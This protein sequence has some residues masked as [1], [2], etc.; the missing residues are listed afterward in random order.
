MERLERMFAQ[1]FNE[2]TQSQMRIEQLERTMSEAVQVAQQLR[3]ENEQLQLHI[4]RQG[5]DIQE[6]SHRR[7]NSLKPQKPD[8]FNGDRTEDVEGF[9][10]TLK[11]FLR[12]SGVPDAL[13][14]D[15]TASFLRKQADKWYRIQ[16]QTRGVNSP[17]A[18]QF[19]VFEREFV[20]Q[21]KPV[22]SLT[23]A[24]D[25]LAKLK[26]M[27]SVTAYTHKFLELKLEAVDMDEA[28]SKDRYIRGL[29]P[30]VFRKVRMENPVGRTLNDVIMIAQQ[31]DEA[32]YNSRLAIGGTQR[33]S[34]GKD[35]MEL[36]AIDEVDE[37]DEA[38][39][40]S[41][42]TDEE[43]SSSLA[44]LKYRAPRKFQHR[45]QSRNPVR[46]AAKNL[47]DERSRCM[48]EGLCFNCK[49]TGHRIANCPDRGSKKQKQ[50]KGKAQ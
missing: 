33:A 32:V 38:P 12:L 37:F 47:M 1:M 5:Q 44:A 28:E 14:V 2:N 43:S 26:Q 20:H 36:D 6:L 24:R 3:Q 39:M 45:K 22:N 40:E 11:R 21:F 13:W 30:H 49:K 8:C 9:L 29:K 4:N 27:G 23:M 15:Y 48:N 46:K 19:G 18:R 42:F 50:G 16:L 7:N 17:F 41:E 10:S 25:R 35:D 34:F 31:Y